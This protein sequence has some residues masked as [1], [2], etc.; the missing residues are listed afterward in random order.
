MMYK[1][2]QQN[3]DRIQRVASHATKES[4]TGRIE[5]LPSWARE[6]EEYF[7]SLN[8]Q[9]DSLRH[10]REAAEV[11]LRGIN[12][13]LRVGVPA[14]VDLS[15][16]K[17]ERERVAAQ[18]VELQRESARFRVITR[19][20]AVNAWGAVYYHCAQMILDRETRIK[21]E[22]A[23]RGFLAR[24]PTADL[25]RANSELS[26]HRRH[27]DMKKKQFKKTLGSERHRR[28]AGDALIYS[29]EK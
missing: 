20:A 19:E 3:L 5:D 4:P 27:Q 18:L 16:V 28:L 23:C 15:H 14:N 11:K 7:N 1:G 13:K 26:E 21:I 17:R 29:T 6:A 8:Q 25:G 10:Q 22:D 24:N 9:F 12:D 2:T